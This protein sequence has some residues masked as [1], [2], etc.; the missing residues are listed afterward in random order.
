[1]VSGAVSVAVVSG[2]PGSVELER[3]PSAL[4]SRTT[5]LL[6][7]FPPTVWMAI[8]SELVSVCDY[9][10]GMYIGIMLHR[11]L[12]D[13]KILW[14]VT[15]LCRGRGKGRERERERERK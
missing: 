15:I 11:E 12:C 3:L 4:L 7:E 8:I 2:S 5:S 14:H 6:E 1:M 13:L 10:I 9:I